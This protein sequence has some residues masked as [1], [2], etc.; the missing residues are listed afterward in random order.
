MLGIEDSLVKSWAASSWSESRFM[1]IS[2]MVWQA[3]SSDQSKVVAMGEVEVRGREQA[4]Q[5]YQVA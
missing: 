2:E 3:V 4:I 1:L 5:V